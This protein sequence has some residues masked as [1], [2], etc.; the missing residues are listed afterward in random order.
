MSLG[1]PERPVGGLA[2]RAPAG[3]DLR[4]LG[5]SDLADAVRLARAQR[6]LSAPNDVAAL[7]VRFEA[8]LDSVDVVPFLAVDAGEAIGL[9]I[10]HFR[11]RLNFPTFEG[12]ISELVV[13]EGHR[14]RGVGRALLQALIAEW[15]LR[16]S[17]RLQVKVPDGATAA[18]ELFGS[19]GLH[20]WMLDFR[21]R[22]VVVPDVEAVVGLTARRTEAGDFDAVTA[23]ISQFGAPRTP[24]AERGDAVRRTFAA[25]LADVAAGRAGSN[26]ALV[27]GEVVGVCAVEW[28]RPFWTDEVH[29]WLPDLIVDEAHRGQGIGRALLADAVARAEGVGAAQLS[30]ESGAQR[31][32]AHRL[33]RSMGFGQPGHT[34]LLRRDPP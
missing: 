11:R 30:L 4:P 2:V 29:G 7:A 14:G 19:A 20:D 24:A 10:L 34:W 15:R 27:A 16:G 33:Y 17:H 8:L 23:L 5:R 22:P 13:D 1:N 28:Q 9:G 3:V 6:G 12:W 18:A 25:H 31:E 32:A 21:L 26:V